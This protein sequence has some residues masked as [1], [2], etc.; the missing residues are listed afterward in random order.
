MFT[1]TRR[2]VLP[3]KKNRVGRLCVL[4]QKW[5]RK[6]GATICPDQYTPDWQA[7]HFPFTPARA[8]AL[9]MLWI[10]RRASFAGKQGLE[11]LSPA[12]RRLPQQVVSPSLSMRC[13][14]KDSLSP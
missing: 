6:F 4:R 2:K 10:E 7:M 5:G 9:P 8:M 13:R 11:E 12:P 1:N 14:A 3:G